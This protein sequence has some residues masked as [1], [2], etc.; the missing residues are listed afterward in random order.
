MHR[1]HPSRAYRLK[2]SETVAE[3]MCRI[4]T[5]RAGNALERLR[6]IDP[7]DPDFADA[8]HGARKDLKK[9]RTV[10][11]LLR[12]QLGEDYEAESHHYRD[13]GRILSGSRDA[14]VKLETL[15]ALAER[16]TSLPAEAA[17]DW[18]EA[19]RRE[20]DRSLEEFD[21]MASFEAIELIETGR[22]R[23]EAW[24]LEVGS[25]QLIGGGVRRVYGA[26]RRAMRRAAAEPSEES[27]H[28]WRKRA[29]DL[30][31]TLR[32][33][34]PAWPAVLGAAAEEAHALGDLLGDHH[35]LAILRAD[36]LARALPTEQSDPLLAAILARQSELAAAAFD[37]G[38]RV[39]AEKPAAFAARLHAYWRAWREDG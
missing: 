38:G 4:A 32:L 20:R 22:D 21:Q 29:K 30:W 31:Y 5:G 28:A 33:L 39:Y 23:I 25:R 36:L 9:L 19:L 37:L 34:H 26:G 10:L 2:R 8:V 27:F 6:G 16:S 35:D 18:R 15:D 3:G 17:A 14:Q 12:D 1:E 7:A 13:A 11:R 24:E